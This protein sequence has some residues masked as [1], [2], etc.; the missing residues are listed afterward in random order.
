M[1]NFTEERVRI[2]QWLNRFG[3]RFE[4]GF[5]VV[6]PSENYK[7]N[8]VNEAFTKVTGIGIE[9]LGRK[10]TE[11]LSDQETTLLFETMKEQFKKGHSTKVEMNRQNQDG[12]PVW[13]EVIMQPVL[14]KFGQAISIVGFV[15][16][17]TKRK[18]NE[19]ILKL[20]ECI[21]RGLHEGKKLHQIMEDIRDKITVFIPEA[22]ACAYLSKENG[23]WC[24]EK[25]AELSRALFAELENDMQ[26]DVEALQ[27]RTL[28]VNQL[29]P[30]QIHPYVESWNMPIADVE[31]EITN[32]FS[33][34]TK[35]HNQL[36]TESA[37]YLRR[38]APIIQMA[39]AF[40]NQQRKMKWLAYSDPTTGLPNHHSIIREINE[41]TGRAEHFFLAIIQPAEYT[42]IINLYGRTEIDNLFLQFTKRIKRLRGKKQSFI[43]KTTTEAI[44]LIA[45][46][47]NNQD[48]KKY[49]K[50]IQSITVEPFIVAETEMYMTLK[51]GVAESKA[52]CY[53]AE[54][55][56][57]RA[58]AA[59]ASSKKQAG[60][61]VSVYKEM[62]NEQETKEL[63]VTTELLK[64]LSA[65][66]I[67]VYLQPKV[68]L[69]T[70]EIIGFEALARWHSKKLGF[71][72]PG[73][74]I[75]LAEKNGSI[76]E[77][78]KQVLGK[79]LSWLGKR[80]KAGKK[81]YQIAV[82]ISVDHFFDGSF[83]STLTKLISAYNI[84]P[85]YLKLE[86][87]ESIGLVDFKN[88][89]DV[90]N[91]LHNLGF[92]IS[93]DDFGIGYSSL[94]YL[95]KLLV[96]EL[97]ID[98]SFIN[99]I[100]GE[101]T[102]AVVTTIQQLA[103]N[104]KVCTVAEGVE[105]AYQVEALLKIGYQVGQGYYFYKPMPMDEATALLEQANEP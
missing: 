31:G 22:S 66:E 98:R 68:I 4:L 84:P 32:I 54:E 17:V 24:I 28:I 23:K 95:P 30:S 89:K 43:G 60:C 59:L 101:E 53:S 56:V 46:A 42:S 49:L 45:T 14:N 40:F 85:K 1:S 64:A 70:G 81:M 63:T 27:K 10:I 39:M 91:E 57:R 55:L 20:Q 74:F 16:D 78:E 80:N 21:L 58:D 2:E 104:L 92:E 33:V 86:M 25:T 71:V 97:K 93:I 18:T 6:N 69:K 19:S 47:E 77:L 88:A 61:V 67:D 105:E 9:Q 99:G 44:V 36:S 13:V 12:S 26:F 72:S 35:E 82:N 48:I 73:E 100:E 94:S 37:D 96:D 50:E 41:R 8:Y 51:I 5:F 90:F 15:F 87:T 11:L 75:P 7:I 3:S 65:C 29:T 103:T 38:I 62:R 79:V 102:H 76:I 34:Y 83:I 52:Y